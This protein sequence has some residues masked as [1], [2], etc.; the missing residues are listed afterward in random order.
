M[1]NKFIISTK[2]VCRQIVLGELDARHLRP[3]CIYS[4][5]KRAFFTQYGYI[6]EEDVLAALNGDSDMFQLWFL[7]FTLSLGRN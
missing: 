5:Q 3:C 4:T 2:E 1:P 7:G 6:P